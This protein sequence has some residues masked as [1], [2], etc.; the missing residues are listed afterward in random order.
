M[1]K[2]VFMILMLVFYTMILF[3]FVNWIAQVSSSPS[4]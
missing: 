4:S 1:D 2:A 3:T